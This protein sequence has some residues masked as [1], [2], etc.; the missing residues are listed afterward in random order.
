MSSK[1][2]LK[3]VQDTLQRCDSDEVNSI[4]DTTDSENAALTLKTVYEQMQADYDLPSSIQHIA[5]GNTDQTSTEGKTR[6]IIP[7]STITIQSFQYD[8]RQAAGDQPSFG[9]LEYVSNETFLNRTRNRDKDATGY[10][11]DE[12]EWP[13]DAQI[14][15]VV[16]NDRAPAFY[17]IVEEKYVILDSYDSDLESTSQSSK[18]QAQVITEKGLILADTT[19]VDLPDILMHY[20]DI[21]T[22]EVHQDLYHGGSTPVVAKMARRAGIRIQRLRDI[23]RQNNAGV[24]YGRG[25]H[26]VGPTSREGVGSTS[27]AT[28]LPTW[29]P[30]D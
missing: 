28:T 11:S 1:N 3:L 20:L 24:D 2:V 9:Y 30:Q 17:T 6:L 14:K 29:W 13:T 12:Q 8:K 19:I 7:D 16:R 26:K 10:D 25:S 4:G 21:K 22:T 5:L 15:F 23:T 27:P 18:S